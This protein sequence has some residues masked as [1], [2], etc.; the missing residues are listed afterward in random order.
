MAVATYTRERVNVR[1][2]HAQYQGDWTRGA[3]VVKC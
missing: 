3:R 2:G 1:A